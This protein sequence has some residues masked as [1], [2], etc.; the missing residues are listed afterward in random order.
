MTGVL[1]LIGSL[2]ASSIALYIAT[3]GWKKSDERA[4]E[5]R[6]ERSRLRQADLLARLLDLHF[7]AVG[8]NRLTMNDPQMKA[9][10]LTLP[11]H[12]ATIL[13]LRLKLDYTVRAVPLDQA[14]AARLQHYQQPEAGDKWMLFDKSSRPRKTAF[15]THPEWVEAELAYDIAGLRG[16]DQD[17][18]L[19][20]LGYDIRDPK[21]AVVA[22]LQERRETTQ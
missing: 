14:T 18:V 15:D 11:G 16:E 19:K 12:L 4:L 2:I 20:A 8:A 1:S 6:D 9:I 13:R 3:R 17:A 7:T 21:D 10:L 5:D 22:M